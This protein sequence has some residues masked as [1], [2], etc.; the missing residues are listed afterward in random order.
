VGH[1]LA[2]LPLVALSGFTIWQQYL[3]DEGM[4]SAERTYFA[5]ATR[6]PPSTSLTVRSAVRAGAEAQG[7]ALVSPARIIDGKPTVLVTVSIDGRQS[8]IVVPV[9]TEASRRA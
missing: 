6:S 1:R 8:P 9:P 5:Q 3:R 2:I 7:K 4:V